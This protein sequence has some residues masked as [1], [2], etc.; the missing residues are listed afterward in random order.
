MLDVSMILC[1]E[2]VNGGRNYP[3]WDCWG[4]VRYVFNEIH[5][6]MLPSLGGL[7]AESLYGKT[8][9]R[10]RVI[11]H[12][13]ASQAEHGAIVEVVTGDACAHVGIVIDYNGSLMV[14]ETTPETGPRMLTLE[15]FK[16]EYETVVYHT[17]AQA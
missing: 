17:H 8:K 5:G 7:N 13:A 12:L 16:D 6:V 15:E 4:L 11:D 3:H 9:A 1:S 14:L 2:Y 10:K